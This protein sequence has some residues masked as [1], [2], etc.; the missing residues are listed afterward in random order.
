MRSNNQHMRIFY[1]H[2]WLKIHVFQWGP[3]LIPSLTFLSRGLFNWFLSILCHSPSLFVIVRFM[4]HSIQINRFF[5]FLVPY[6]FWIGINRGLYIEINTYVL[7]QS[8]SLSLSY[9]HR[10]KQ[11]LESVAIASPSTYTGGKRHCVRMD[12]HFL[13]SQS[14][15]I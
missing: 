13:K 12:N 3:A 9:Y 14:T 6:L 1:T 4:I 8:V 10:C 7:C 15:S 2:Q 11:R 5:F